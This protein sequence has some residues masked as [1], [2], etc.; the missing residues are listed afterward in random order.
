VAEMK[1]QENDMLLL[2]GLKNAVP[3]VTVNDI[4]LFTLRADKS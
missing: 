3:D 4:N 2:T 1:M